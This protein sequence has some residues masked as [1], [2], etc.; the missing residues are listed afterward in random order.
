APTAVAGAVISEQEAIAAAL[1][2][3]TNGDGHIS[4]AQ[5]P[6]RSTHAQLMLADKDRDQLVAYGVSRNAADSLHGAIWLITLDGTWS[7]NGP[8]QL[9][10]TTAP[11]LE[12]LH[13]LIV[14]LDAGT[15]SVGVVSG[16]P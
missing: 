5:E 9:P 6:P 3:G 15:G 7:L 14:V 1:R 12:P 4:Q 16:K 2:Y 13:H 11:L 8:P 10:G